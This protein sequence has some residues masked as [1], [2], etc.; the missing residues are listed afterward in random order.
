MNERF[1][2]LARKT[3]T[4]VCLA[5]ICGGFTACHD[6]Y[7]LDDEGNYPS[8]LG[9]SIYDA[10]DNPASVVKDDK[11]LLTGTFKNYLR[12]IDDLDYKETMSRTGSKTVFAAN[13]EAFARFFANNNWGVTKYED[14]TVAM[15]KQ[16]LNGSMLDNALL[17]EM[18]SN[19]SGSGETPIIYGMAL[20]HKLAIELNDSVTLLKG[21]ENMPVNN[22]YWEPYYEKGIH[23]WMDATSPMIVHFTEEQMT[24]N[25]ITTRGDDSDFEVVTGTKYIP[26]EHSAYIF[27]N[28][29][30]SPD[31]TCKNG[32]IHQ[33]EDVLVPP[34]NMAQMLRNSSDSK[35]FSR[36]LDRFAAPFF[37]PDSKSNKLKVKTAYED[38]KNTNN[39]ND[40]AQLNGLPLIDSIF[41]MRYISNYSHGGYSLM[42]DPFTG[43]DVTTGL[44]YDPG[45]N[46]LDNQ[47]NEDPIR[48]ISAMFV[49]TDE[50]LANFFISGE[51]KFLMEE[52]GKKEG[53]VLLNDR[54]HLSE[55]IDSIPLEN[56]Q[57]LINNLMKTSFV[58]TVPSKFDHVMDEANDPMGLSLSVLNKTAD[59]KYNVKIANNGVIYMLDKMFAPPSLVAV[60]AP[61]SL[62]SDMRIMNVAINDGKKTEPLELN[63]NYYAYLLA[64]SAN[65]A[66][67]IPTDDAFG[68]YYVDPSSLT[69]DEPR[70]LKFYYQKTSPFVYCSTWKCLKN[71]QGQWEI[72]DSI[73]R[74]KPADF[75]SQFT[76]LLNYHTVVLD[77]GEKLG[78]G[79]RKY[80]KTKH[81][82]EIYFDGTTVRSGAQLEGRVPVSNITQVYNQKNGVTYALD[83]V[84][85]APQ[86]SVL[87]V[88]QEDTATTARFSEFLSLCNDFD[89]DELLK[90]S[91][92]RLAEK[93]DVTNKFRYEAYHT[94]VAK[95]GLT[96]NVNYFNSYNYTVYAPNND[97]MKKAYDAGLPTWGDIKLIYD[98]WNPVKEAYAKSIGKENDDI[99]W[100]EAVD[101]GAF[102]DDKEAFDADRAKALAMAETINDFIRYHFQDNSVYADQVIETGEFSTACTDTLGIRQ[103]LT[104]KN[105]NMAGQFIVVDNS[106]QEITIDGNNTTQYVNIMTRDYELNKKSHVINNSSFA[107]VHEI[108]TPL[109]P[110]NTAAAGSRRY[111][112]M[113]TG[114]GAKQRL[115]DFRKRF[116]TKYFDR[117]DGTLKY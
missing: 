86:R 56:V 69:D 61:A 60:S 77:E 46:E 59:G 91:S 41:Q 31:V 102:N 106:H 27:R 68:R 73:G 98:K 108:S 70:A 20:K 40:Y 74:L 82:G 87:N 34:G 63:L 115:A 84:I 4:G 15:K 55:N 80:Y 88:L 116:E 67:F 110:K 44:N 66:F 103:R 94:F 92:D 5:M 21:K 72:G 16:L 105:G 50:A 58:A 43:Q 51:G 24:M 100:K 13:D 14:L 54:E 107:V 75:R 19:I 30:I 52:F 109:N 83:H 85:Q 76:D 114:A 17:V 37:D 49:P 117:Y 53:G 1:L 11:Q 64:M 38:S 25:S 65:Y 78:D 2:K 90:F 10:L 62:K 23:L 89:M 111:D 45:W 39:Y 81:G 104:V 99:T 18:L 96:D 29:I 32:Y 112:A 6:D 47:Q 42:I 35:L 57:Q 26:E 79:G 48:D 7:D 9:S 33:M 101:K 113:W 36:M 97:A 8:W 93:N 95:N 28:K 3:C 12:L 22:K 71:A